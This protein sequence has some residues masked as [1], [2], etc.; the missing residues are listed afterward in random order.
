MG[1]AFCSSYTIF[2]TDHGSS[3]LWSMDSVHWVPWISSVV[4]NRPSTMR[5]MDLVFCGPWTYIPCPSSVQ[6]VH[7]TCI[8][9]M[10]PFLIILFNSASTC[11]SLKVSHVSY[12]TIL[13]RSRMWS[14]S[15]ARYC[16]QNHYSHWLFKLQ[17][18]RNSCT[19]QQLKWMVFLYT[20]SEPIPC[21]RIR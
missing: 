19:A 8:R 16:E 18:W 1:L 17:L 15:Y 4:G 2:I 5:A 12:P 9:E 10:W 20:G 3:P 7:R 13:S 11:S 14:S 21:G 6:W